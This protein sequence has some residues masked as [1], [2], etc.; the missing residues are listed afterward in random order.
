[1]SDAGASFGFGPDGADGTLEGD[2]AARVFGT[3]LKKY[4]EKMGKFPH[5]SCR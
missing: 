5:L 2:F 3:F 1:M 4:K